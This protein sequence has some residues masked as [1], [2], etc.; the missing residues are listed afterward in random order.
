MNSQN[1]V[2]FVED[3]AVISKTGAAEHTQWKLISAKVVKRVV[4]LSSKDKKYSS[5]FPNLTYFFIIERHSGMIFKIIKG[6]SRDCLLF[7]L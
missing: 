5:K 2:D 7:V 3:D 6:N 1:E 4:V